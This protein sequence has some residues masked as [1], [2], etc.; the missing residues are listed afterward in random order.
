MNK[1][2]Y[3]K[4]TRQAKISIKG[5]SFFG[6]LVSDYCIPHQIVGSKD[7]GLDYICEWVYDEKPTGVLFAVQI[8]TFSEETAKPKLIEECNKYNHLKEYEI[9]NSNLNIDEKTLFY[10]KGFGIPIYLFAICFNAQGDLDCYYK[11]FTPVLTKEADLKNIN[12]HSDY[13]KINDGHKF[14]AFQDAEKRTL[15]FA[16]DLFIDYTRCNYSK[17][18]II[19]LNPRN[20][21]LNQFPEGNIFPDLFEEYKE[22][23]IATYEKTR[24]YLESLLKK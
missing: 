17:G 24:T 7:I 10:W 4:Y 3:K 12:Y 11:R 18:S 5:E 23:I 20:I 6:S 9:K 13:Y 16:R 2:D 15:G 14:L 22:E 21:G 8:K 1:G 19:Y